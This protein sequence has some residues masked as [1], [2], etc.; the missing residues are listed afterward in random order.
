MEGYLGHSYLTLKT[1]DDRK[2]KAQYTPLTIVKRV[3]LP[4]DTKKSLE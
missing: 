3:K 2:D 1:K 4:S